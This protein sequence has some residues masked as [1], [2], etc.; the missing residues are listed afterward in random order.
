[1][2]SF[3]G[4]VAVGFAYFVTLLLFVNL[5]EYSLSISSQLPVILIGGLSGLLGSVIDSVLGATVQFSGYSE[6]LGHVVNENSPGVRHISGKNIL[7]NHQVNFVSSLLTAIVVPLSW[8]MY[9]TL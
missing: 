3:A 4:G 7:D 6:K 2:V 9:V 1:M 5:S 8:Y